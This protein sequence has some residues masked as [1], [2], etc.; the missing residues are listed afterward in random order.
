M[1]S[2]NQSEVLDDVS[3]SI[4]PNAFQLVKLSKTFPIGSSECERS[5]SAIRRISNF[6]RSS[7]AQQRLSNLGILNIERELVDRLN[8]PDIITEFVNTKDRRLS[9]I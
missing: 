2:N 9:L 1:F 6:L 7:M 5:F 8:V 3:K 4:Y